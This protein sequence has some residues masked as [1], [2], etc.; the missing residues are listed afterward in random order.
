M[1]FIQNN[2]IFKMVIDMLNAEFTENSFKL[3]NDGELTD[4]DRETLKSFEKNRWQ[5]LYELAFSTPSPK[6]KKQT[7]SV[8]YLH[9]LAVYFLKTLKNSSDITLLRH[10]TKPVL[11]REDIQDLIDSAPF[12]LG[13]QYIDESWIEN[14]LNKFAEAF[15]KDAE[16][17]NGTMEDYF[18]SKKAGIKI[19]ERV[20]FHLVEHKDEDY[21]FAFMATYATVDK[22]GNVRHVPL[23]YALTEYKKDRD[24]L[25]NL[26]SCLNRASAASEFIS[27]MVESGEMFHPLR[28]TAKETLEFLKDI[29]K[30][31]EAGILCRVP[32]WWRKRNSSVKLAVKIGEK[33]KSLLGLDTLLQMQPKLIVDGVELTK[34]DIDKLLASTDG[35]SYLKGKWIEVDKKRLEELLKTLSDYEG[36]IS[37]LSALR[38]EAG[39]NKKLNKD[40][41]APE[42]IHGEWLKEL[43]K[44][45][46]SPKELPPLDVPKTVRA[47]LRPY[48]KDGFNWLFNMASLG[49]G[50]CLADDMGLGK[51]LEVLT[52]LE[53]FRNKNKNAH[54][55]LIVPAS[56][57]SNWTKEAK[58]FTPEISIKILHGQ[59]K[60]VLA[61]ELSNLNSMVTITTYGM[62]QRIEKLKE[63]KWDAVILDEAQAI[64]NPGTK[65]TKTIKEIPAA[66]RIALTGT[67]I[68]NDLSN[69]WS[70]FD[71][72][73]RGLLGSAKEFSEFTKT[74]SE[75][76]KGYDRL[77]KMISP[78]IL[79]R[80]K[81]DKNIIADL[82]DKIEQ[83]D[84][85]APQK[86]Q[87]VL[88]RKEVAELEYKLSLEDNE[89][90]IKRQ[91]LVLSA[92]TKLKQ[93]CNHPDQFLGNTVFKPEESGKFAM[94]EEICEVIRSKRERVLVFTQYREM[95]KP[96][97]DFLAKIFGQKGLI[98]HG[99]T[100]VKK[101]P[102][103][104][105]EFNGE[106]Y[107]PF[108]VLSVKAAGTGL[109][110]TAAN[111]VIHFD[112]WWNPAVENQATDRAFR[113]GQ[114]KN[115]TVH[116]FV[117][118]GTI[119]ERI[120][121]IISGKKELAEGVIGDGVKLL[122]K[123]SNEELI[124]LLKF[125]MS[126]G[127]K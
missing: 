74:L 82:P 32:N 106:A 10:K 96:L 35:L 46:R 25:M 104:V 3:Y 55:L 19:P 28:F 42:F 88:Y 113:I 18:Q 64:K 21:P 2:K 8:A 110:L 57:L 90:G 54:V 45:L 9:S 15:S 29:P 125:D 49:F 127:G 120:D 62:A 100:P 103:I 41:D 117:T 78:F 76:D 61:E 73:N 12:V 4:F 30:F 1:W 70:L 112:R 17:F 36:D 20:F 75:S 84:Y 123:M 14:A 23:N 22:D 94:L 87:I 27:L 44:N 111:H 51:T 56:L 98:I 69:L 116:K 16:T 52:F 108:M 66:I 58:K 6:N 109:N 93:I 59:K 124:N 72:L 40:K 11:S 5:W 102:Q 33:K 97:A 85:I 60:E 50:A 99:G 37:V 95:T 48:Q 107:S 47:K 67:P 83:I 7:R 126:D 101:R 38:A 39:L 119:E 89:A 34:S 121:E 71:F 24:K 65:Q 13:L 118:E 43:L 26:L 53:T 86:K 68:E 79:R 31:E 77:K 63:I 114:K 105:E 92:I 81:T 80:V 115:V 122:T 91:G